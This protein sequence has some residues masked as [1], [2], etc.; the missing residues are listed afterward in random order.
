MRRAH[1]SIFETIEFYID[2]FGKNR[3]EHLD[4]CLLKI[5]FWELFWGV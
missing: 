5:Q 3:S 1:L 2:P 4:F